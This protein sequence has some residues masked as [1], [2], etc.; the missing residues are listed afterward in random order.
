MKLPN[1][2][3]M[4]S[5]LELQLNIKRLSNRIVDSAKQTE[6]TLWTITFKASAGMSRWINAAQKTRNEGEREAGRGSEGERQ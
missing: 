4:R 5:K 1:L 3:Q 2:Q 6:Y